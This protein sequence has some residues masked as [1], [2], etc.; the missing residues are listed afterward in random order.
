MTESGS[1][2][3]EGT[4]YG[5]IGIG[6]GRV[7]TQVGLTTQVSY[8][9]LAG[10]YDICHLGIWQG[11]G[12]CGDTNDFYPRFYD[13]GVSGRM[14]GT[15]D[16]TTSTALPYPMLW[17]EMDYSNSGATAIKGTAFASR[18]DTFNLNGPE[19]DIFDQGS[20]LNWQAGVSGAGAISAAP[21]Q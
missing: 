2:S 16:N 15:F 13:P 7:Q 9:S 6:G 5:A 17:C 8:Q 1:G 10:E 14:D 11:G 18:L 19:A 21:K 20:T 4:G 3:T 12:I